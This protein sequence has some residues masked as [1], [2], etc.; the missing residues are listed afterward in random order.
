MIIFLTEEP[1]SNETCGFQAEPTAPSS[2]LI[3]KLQNLFWKFLENVYLFSVF[4]F[5]AQLE[6]KIDTMGI[7]V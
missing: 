7:S 3:M 1:Q 5:F 6:D 4:V 2:G